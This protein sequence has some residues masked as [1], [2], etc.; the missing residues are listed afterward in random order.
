MKLFLFGSTGDLVKRK[1]FPALQE[2]LPKDTQIYALGRRDFSKDD[3]KKLVSDKVSSEILD[4]IEYHKVNFEGEL[5]K[6]CE[7]RLDYKKH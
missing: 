7:E 3:Y 4:K 6:A 2:V 5:C 1:I